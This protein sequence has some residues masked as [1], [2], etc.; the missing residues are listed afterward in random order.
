MKAI[1]KIITGSKPEF[2]A[3][4]Q[5]EFC[6]ACLRTARKRLETMVCEL[7]EIGIALKYNWLTP[8]QAVAWMSDLGV[9]LYVNVDLWRGSDKGAEAA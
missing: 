2:S 5:S 3:E 4:D 6:L 9:L 8:P 1:P 7:D